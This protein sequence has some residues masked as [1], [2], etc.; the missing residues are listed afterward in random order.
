MA[1]PK[2]EY[3]G[4][5]G[6][7][8][9]QHIDYPTQLENKRKF[10]ANQ[11]NYPAD[12]IT[13][14]Y[15]NEYFYRNRMDM[16]FTKQGIGFR[17]KDKWSKI[18]D[19][20]FCTISNDQ[21]NDLIKEI[22]DF[23]QGKE[24]DYYDVKKNTGTFKYAVIRATRNDSS[25]S[26]VLNSNS[27]RIEGAAQMIDQFAKK[28][29]ASNILVTYV[30][31]DDSTS[32]EYYA[33]KGGEYLMETL[34]NKD[35]FYHAEG[36]FQNNTAMAEKMQEYC[37]E[38][39]SKYDT[40]K[41]HLLDLYGGV[42]T[43][44]IINSDLFKDVLIVEAVDMAIDAANKNIAQNQIANAKAVVLDAKNIYKLK[45]EQRRPLYVINDPPRSGMHQK[46]IETL[47]TLKPEVIIYISCNVE[48]LG[49]DILKFRNYDIKSVAM[50]DLFPQTKHIEGIVELVK[51]T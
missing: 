2:C 4:K 34:L 19:V 20:D 38:L 35:F 21:L 32:N 46:T 28:T 6:G 47:N 8:A 40:S 9:L 42:G 7:C 24:I 39:L 37:R 45:L 17:E 1:T 48:Q 43:F 49:K 51:K 41:A 29:T 26:F 11:I 22:R 14:V 18:V 27:T 25:I 3:F 10:F 12:R 16:I 50:F 23:C 31:N 15:D 44:G 5:C 30:E 36:F 13:I 33:V